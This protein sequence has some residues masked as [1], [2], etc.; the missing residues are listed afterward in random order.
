M[1]AAGNKVSPF[2]THSLITFRCLLVHTG[3][4]QCRFSECS[5]HN[6]HFDLVLIW[7]HPRV[8]VALDLHPV[9]CRVQGG[10]SKWSHILWGVWSSQ[11]VQ[12]HLMDLGAVCSVL[13]SVG[14]GQW[15]I[16]SVMKNTDETHVLSVRTPCLNVQPD[17]EFT[18]N[19]T[20]ER[21]WRPRRQSWS[22]GL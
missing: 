17:T 13:Q 5:E 7:T 2:V 16:Y 11:D 4:Q 9:Q 1:L 18:P 3:E 21:R 10:V 22:W 12:E 20:G 19:R 14:M 15:E 6:L 8:E